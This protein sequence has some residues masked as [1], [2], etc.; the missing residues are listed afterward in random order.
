MLR[1]KSLS[2]INRW[3]QQIG[4]DRLVIL[5]IAGALL[6]AVSSPVSEYAG[7]FRNDKEKQIKGET[8]TTKNPSA[9]VLKERMDGTGMDSQDYIENTEKRLKEVLSKIKGAGK[10]DVI[11]MTNG[12]GELVLEKDRPYERENL[13][14]TDAQGGN[15]SRSTMKDEETTVFWKDTDGKELP[16]IAK[17]LNPKV[18]GVLVVCQGGGNAR[19]KR[20]I[21]DAIMALFDL[22]VHKIKIAEMRSD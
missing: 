7:V 17:E 2:Q 13:N 22:D 9:R 18:T 14:E 3:F 15:R 19:V 1:L 16:F 6:L 20:E 8:D 12:S 5:M 10:T 11:L 4:K 21:S